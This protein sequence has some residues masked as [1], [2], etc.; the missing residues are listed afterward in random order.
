MTPFIHYNYFYDPLPNFYYQNTI[1]K[2]DI[3][4]YFFYATLAQGRTLRRNHLN[5]LTKKKSLRINCFTDVTPHFLNNTHYQETWTKLHLWKDQTPHIE[6]V[7]SLFYEL[8]MY[9]KQ[10]LCNIIVNHTEKLL[11]RKMIGVQVRIGGKRR[12]YTD[13]QFLTTSDISQFYEKID[14]YMNL[15]S[16]ELKDV[17]VF[18]STDDPSVQDLFK[19]K[20]KESVYIVDDFDIGH[21]SVK[22][23]MMNSQKV[24][25][26]TQ[27]AILD[28]LLLQRADYLIY[29]NSS[30]YGYL[31][32][33]LQSNRNSP[34]RIDDYVDWSL[35]EDHCS[36]FERSSRPFLFDVVGKK[37]VQ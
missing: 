3:E 5:K 28:I 15:N 14:A 6:N 23:N 30:S 24:A 29:T 36:V 10:P 31:A 21:S 25:S 22:K 37:T 33:K 16:L 27:R 32:S 34:I 35:H 1:P 11:K 20:Y 17:F 18:V 19:E 7:V 8:V 2:Q 9:P 4:D 13:K 26:F 12:L